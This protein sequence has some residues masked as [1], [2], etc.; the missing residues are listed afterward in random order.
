MFNRIKKLQEKQFIPSYSEL[1]DNKFVSFASRLKGKNIK[2]TACNVLEWQDRNL[3]F[4]EE[5]WLTFNVLLKIVI[6][7]IF[8]LYFYLEGFSRGIT[9]LAC[10]VLLFLALFGDNFL[11]LLLYLVCLFLSIIT[12][13]ILLGLVIPTISISSKTLIFIIAISLL[14]GA[15]ISIILSLA[16]KYRSIKQAIPDF[17]MNDTFKMSLSIS[18]I[19]QYRLSVCRD[20]AKL[21]SALLMH[22]HPE[23]EVFFALIPQHVAVIIEIN[24]KK[25][26]LDQKLPIL[27]LERWAEIW[28]K[29]LKKKTIHVEILKVIID[30]QQVK[31]ELLKQKYTAKKEQRKEETPKLNI[32]IKDLKSTFQIKDKKNEHRKKILVEIVL[33]GFAPRIENKDEI[34]RIS[35]SEAVKNKIEDEL[36]GRIREIHDIKIK[37]INDDLLLTIFLDENETN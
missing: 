13:I 32:L 19:L 8:S 35:V 23:Q 26:V 37:K 15:L 22:I 34:N 21:T 36:V 5:R 25:Y 3:T 7:S 31:T 27:S 6:L 11:N 33:K 12:L 24:K 10:I 18:E 17:K 20:Y 9:L 1:N 29:K 16:M 30:N 14:L 2:Q 28:R 4:W